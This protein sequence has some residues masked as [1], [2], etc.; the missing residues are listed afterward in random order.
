MS[1]RSDESY[2]DVSKK[3]NTPFASLVNQIKDQS[4]SVFSSVESEGG[5]IEAGL[6]ES[7]QVASDPREL[8]LSPDSINTANENNKVTTSS[9]ESKVNTVIYQEVL[10]G[11]TSSQTSSSTVR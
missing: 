6:A 7:T 1:L 3:G 9:T 11:T 5:D 10:I 2:A 4:S 8:K